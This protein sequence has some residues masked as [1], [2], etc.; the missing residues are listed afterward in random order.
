MAPVDRE[1]AGLGDLVALPFGYARAQLIAHMQ[2]ECA[3]CRWIV[4]ADP[5]DDDG[6]HLNSPRFWLTAVSPQWCRCRTAVLG[7]YYGHTYEL[8]RT[9]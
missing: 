5:V 2:K 4:V 1:E 3:K 9:A 7:C 8:S 6:C